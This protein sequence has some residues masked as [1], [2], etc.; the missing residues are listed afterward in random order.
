MLRRIVFFRDGL[1]EGGY[2]GIAQ[3]EIRGSMVQQLATS[4]SSRSYVLVQLAIGNVKFNTH[5]YCRLPNSRLVTSSLPPNKLTFMFSCSSRLVT[6]SLP[7]NKL[8]I[9]NVK[10][11]T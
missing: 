3:Q 5:G 1:I 11:T 9:G 7:P 2:E 6:S 10:F 8:A 4:S